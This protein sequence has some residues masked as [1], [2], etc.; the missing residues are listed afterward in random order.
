MIETL[1]TVALF[2]GYGAIGWGVLWLLDQ[3][4]KERW[5]GTLRDIDRDNAERWQRFKESDPQGWADAE[6]MWEGR[7]ARNES[8][9]AQIARL[10]NEMEDER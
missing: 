7:K 4:R 10:Q 5:S 9:R 3:R 8:R 6:R 2:V 1:N